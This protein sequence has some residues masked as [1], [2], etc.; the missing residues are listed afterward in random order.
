MASTYITEVRV[1]S[2]TAEGKKYPVI[3]AL[4][5]IGYNEQD[6]ISLVE[7]LH[8]EFIVVGIR[9]NLTYE[10]GYAYYYLKNYGNPERELF[11]SSIENLLNVIE[12]TT[13]Q[14][15]VDPSK[16]YLIG[17]SQGAILSMSLALL[18]G[19]K[20]KGVVAMNGYIPNFLIEEFPIK[21]LN[22]TD[23]FLAQGG[24]DPIFPIKIGNE[25]DEYLRK[26]AHAVKYVIYP[27]G[28]EISADTQVDLCRWLRINAKN[29]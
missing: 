12:E 5:G 2:T 3:F 14:Y 8:D 9:G 20:I 26:H 17:F 25:T 16:R 22:Q 23:V 24:S 7:E 4:H 29:E 18:L 1:P 15:P 13:N 6:M 11:D 19:E 27:A 21:S 28:H 10:N